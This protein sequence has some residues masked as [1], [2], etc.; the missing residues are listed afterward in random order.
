MGLSLAGP[1]SVGLGLRVLRWFGVCG[2]SDSGVRFPVPSVIGRGPGLVHRGCFVRTPIPPLA[3]QTTPSPG[4]VRVFVFVLFWAGSGRPSS[5]ARFGACH[6]SCGRCSCLL[7]FFGPLQA[8]VALFLFVSSFWSG[9]FFC[10]RRCPWLSCCLS[11]WPSCVF[12]PFLVFHFVFSVFAAP[13]RFIFQVGLPPCSGLV[14]LLLPPPPAL[15]F[16]CLLLFFLPALFFLRRGLLPACVVRCQ[17]PL[18]CCVL[19]CSFCWRVFP[20]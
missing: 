9:G 4:P 18:R 7:C 8:G 17:L 14:P 11:P 2:S 19:R 15:F 5:R 13:T 1:S 10:R 16:C 3:G 6:L 12:P 20:C